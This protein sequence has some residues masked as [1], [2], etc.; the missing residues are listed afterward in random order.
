MTFGACSQVVATAS[1][2]LA[3]LAPAEVAA[4]RT[5][6]QGAA[7]TARAVEG[8]SQ[9]SA[10]AADLKQQ[11]GNPPRGWNSYDSF[12][13]F[14]NETQFLRNCKYM[15]DHLLEYGYAQHYAADP[16]KT[17]INKRFR[18]LNCIVHNKLSGDRDY[19]L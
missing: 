16:I 15:A 11:S 18:M 13:W 7:K 8:L 12:T 17:K 9:I 19:V 6:W 1:C 2:F 10:S 4:T 5:A 14:V 3:L